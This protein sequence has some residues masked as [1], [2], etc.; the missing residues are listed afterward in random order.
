MYVRDGFAHKD[1]IGDRPFEAD[2]K[3]FEMAFGATIS[4][5]GLFEGH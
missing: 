3:K 5:V 2:A 1:F 4:P